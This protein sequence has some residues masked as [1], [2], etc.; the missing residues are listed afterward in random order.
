M[1]QVVQGKRYEI[2]KEE[3]GRKKRVGNV[4][5]SQSVVQKAIVDN[6]PLGMES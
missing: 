4:V 1:R 2:E 3:K 6:Y 5:V